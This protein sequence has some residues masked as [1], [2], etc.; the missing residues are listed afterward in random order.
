MS[1]VILVID[2][3]K[4][5][6]ECPLRNDDDDCVVQDYESNRVGTFEELRRTCPLK[7][8][9]EKKEPDK[10]SVKKHFEA[11]GYNTCIDEIFGGAEYGKG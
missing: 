8:M 1:K 3:P 7:P 2:M 10:Q 5:C 4:K 9:P 11:I 6:L